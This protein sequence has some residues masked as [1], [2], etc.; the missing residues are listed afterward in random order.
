M[1][2]LLAATAL[3][4]LSITAAIAAPEIGAPAPAFK[5]M[6]PEGN[7]ISLDQYKGKIVIMEWV[8]EGCPYVKKHYGG[9]NMQALQKEMTG[10]GFVWLT[11]ATSAPGKQG[12][13]D[14]S[15]AKA[16]K[17]EKGASPTAILLDEKGVIGRT[18]DAKTTPHMFVIDTKGSVAYMGAIDDKPSAA[19][20]SLEG[21]KNYV[22]TAVAEVAGGKKV[23]EPVT[24]PYGC[25]VKYGT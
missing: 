2:Q 11:V 7:T 25:D 1:R 24:K 20:A 14:A 21:A 12:Y 18:Y 16:W 22:R 15:R 9:N 8:N 4:G 6:T 3:L 13:M 19:P 17:S 23:S 10:K 5:A